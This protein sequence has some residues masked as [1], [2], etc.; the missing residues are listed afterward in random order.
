MEYPE[1]LSQ[2]L[3]LVKWP[4]L[5][6]PH[7]IIVSFFQGSSQQFG[8]LKLILVIFAGVTILFTKRYPSGI[9]DFVMGLNR[10]TFR[11]AA[12]ALLMT[13]RYPPLRLDMRE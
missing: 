9:F 3:V 11:V 2:W 13:D 1:R 8:G 4:F 10:W 6:I 12:Y 7:Y 5:L